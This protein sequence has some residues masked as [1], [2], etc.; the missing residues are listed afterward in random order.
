MAPCAVESPW[1][2][3]PDFC[4]AGGFQQYR[5]AWRNRPDWPVRDTAPDSS[6]SSCRIMPAARH[7][8]GSPSCGLPCFDAHGPRGRRG[9]LR[10]A[11]PCSAGWQQARAMA[12][13]DEASHAAQ[14]GARAGNGQGEG[15]NRRLVGR[16]CLAAGWGGSVGVRPDQYERRPAQAEQGAADNQSRIFASGDENGDQNEQHTGGQAAAKALVRQ[17]GQVE[18]G[19]GIAVGHWYWYESVGSGDAGLGSW[20]TSE[21]LWLPRKVRSAS[22]ACAL[23]VSVR[24]LRRFCNRL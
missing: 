14:K 23:P 10:G 19:R 2:V 5:A 12:W 24:P 3:A 9:P 20:L 8:Q 6:V 15:A 1:S 21:K 13:G 4:W 17:R 7:G 16:G 18:V 22:Y 11:C